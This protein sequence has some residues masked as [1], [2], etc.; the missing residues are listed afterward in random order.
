MLSLFTTNAENG[1]YNLIISNSVK[2]LEYPLTNYCTVFLHFLQLRQ[3]FVHLFPN[4][5]QCD[6]REHMPFKMRE[7]P[8]FYTEI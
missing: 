8:S 7:I 6:C 2:L 3:Y 4:V 5:S 1:R